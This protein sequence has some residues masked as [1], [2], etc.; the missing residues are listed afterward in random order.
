MGNNAREHSHALVSSLWILTIPKSHN[1]RGFVMEKSQPL[2]PKKAFTAPKVTVYG[3]VKVITQNV[4]KG[5]LDD[6]MPAKTA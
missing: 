5:A 1:D 3:D 4:N 2:K 6:G